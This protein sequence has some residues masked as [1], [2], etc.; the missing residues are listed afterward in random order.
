MKK[1]GKDI[2]F[3]LIGGGSYGWAPRFIADVANISSLHGMHIILEDINP[4]ALTRFSH[5]KRVKH[6]MLAFNILRKIGCD[7]LSFPG[8]LPVKLDVGHRRIKSVI[9]NIVNVAGKLARSGGYT[10]LKVR[11]RCPWL[12]PFER[13]FASYC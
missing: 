11:T 7:L 2:K 10:K 8:D 6:A 9:Q 12:N 4:D 3:V 13:L 1:N 5:E